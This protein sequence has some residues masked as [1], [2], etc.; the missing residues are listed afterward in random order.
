M[1]FHRTLSDSKSP[2]VFRT[3]LSILA[4]LKNTVVWM[5]SYR[6]T[7]SQLLQSFGDCTKRTDYHWY[8]RHFHIPQFF[9]FSSKVKVLNS[10]FAC[11]QFYSGLPGWPSPLFDRFSFLLNIT[12]S[13]WLAEIRWS[14][15]SSKT[16]RILCIRFHGQ[17]PGFAYTICLY[18]Q[19]SFF[20]TILSGSP[21]PPYRV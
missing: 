21:S 8:H 16:Q 20:R 19:I 2:Q 10:L 15:C 7:H 3:L 5:V 6:C 12:T 14:I 1:V 11:F 4:V 17:F 13:G 18:D 9:L